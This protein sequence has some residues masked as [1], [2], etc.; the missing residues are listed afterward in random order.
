[1]IQDVSML[2]AGG[3]GDAT[4]VAPVAEMR[5]AP[6]DVEVAVAVG[7]DV[8]ATTDA[9]GGGPAHAV[10]PSTTT[11]P[12]A[13]PR[14]A[15][16]YPKA[17]LD[18]RRCARGRLDMRRGPRLSA[19][20]L[21]LATLVAALAVG[22]KR[23]RAPTVSL[24]STAK[25]RTPN[26]LA[27]GGRL[28]AP[29]IVVYSNEEEVYALPR[30]SLSQEATLVSTD[31][32]TTCAEVTLR[33]MGPRVPFAETKSWTVR[34]ILDDR[35]RVAPSEESRL[36]GDATE[37]DGRT[38]SNER[39]GQSFHCG[40]RDS[41]G[42]C[43]QRVLAADYAEVT[44]AAKIPL[45]ATTTRLC[46]PTA[47]VFTASTRTIALDFDPPKSPDAPDGFRMIWE[48]GP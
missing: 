7:T 32:A 10:T 31:E 40:H 39:V 6:V 48:L 24:R 5:G 17:S 28:Q 42:A 33:Q 36:R 29:T 38:T 37:A 1:V 46:F 19:L 23:P 8:G 44:K 43:D 2:G 41:T 13:T 27:T 30:G 9:G 35:T 11:K 34:L 16:V 45:A 4:V 18:A 14:M 47:G 3:G 15:L 20:A 21:A 26:P 25:A 22:C 12:A